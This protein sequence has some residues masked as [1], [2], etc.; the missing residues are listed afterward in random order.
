MSRSSKREILDDEGDTTEE[1][2]LYE[3]YSC[4]RM[5]GATPQGDGCHGD[6][7]G[8]FLSLKECQQKCKPLPFDILEKINNDYGLS[9]SRLS[10]TSKKL[11]Q[12]TNVTRVNT[13]TVVSRQFARLCTWMVHTIKTVDIAMRTGG[14]KV[15]LSIPQMT[16]MT[17]PRKTMPLNITYWNGKINVESIAGKKIP[18]RILQEN[19]KFRNPIMM[20][21]IDSMPNF[22]SKSMNKAVFMDCVLSEMQT[23]RAPIFPFHIQV[24]AEKNH[25]L[26]S[27][28]IYQ[29]QIVHMNT[30]INT[31]IGK[32][33]FDTI[34]RD[35]DSSEE[36]Y[37]LCNIE[38][39]HDP[40]LQIFNTWYEEPNVGDY[41]EVEEDAEGDE[42][43]NGD[44]EDEPSSAE[45]NGVLEDEPSS[46]EYNGV[47]EDEPSF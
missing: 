6:P 13:T 10:Q 44:W 12:S 27:S 26:K 9:T 4:N 46:A 16:E 19:Y 30:L 11:K 32:I 43:Y 31:K 34:E 1:E 41:R 33:V 22:F 7:N 8:P 36:M 35:D 40:S 38:F 17:I 39:A 21:I 14:Y 18:P 28:S 2:P 29:Q 24:R 47:W 45:Y 20:Q 37:I 42:E 15:F 23:L 3:R 5:G 25:Y